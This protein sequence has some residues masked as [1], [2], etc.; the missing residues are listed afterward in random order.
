MYIASLLLM[1]QGLK[2][3]R[4]ALEGKIHVVSIK[5]LCF[6]AGLMFVSNLCY[7]KLGMESYGIFLVAAILILLVDILNCMKSKISLKNRIP[8]W[9]GV[10]YII[11]GFQTIVWI[12][13]IMPNGELFTWL[14]FI[15]T[16]VS[17][18][19]A[20]FTGKFFGSR[21][22]IP[23][24][25]PNKTIEG[26]LGAIFFAVIACVLYSFILDVEIW[27]MIMIGF[28]GSILSQVGDLIASKLKRYAQ[29]KD[30]S[31]L[32]PQHGGVLDR[33]DSA[34]LVSQ[35]VFVVIILLIK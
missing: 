9:M 11:I 18:S 16:I 23:S 8:F 6:M 2:E 32:I 15:I 26:S 35:F 7:S 29:I 5:T 27:Q 30:F 13:N 1:L 24:V 20:Y 21:K 17:D 12:R 25:S 19:M 31:N 3:Y 4:E 22:L 33:L 14:I 34:L 28:F 10:F